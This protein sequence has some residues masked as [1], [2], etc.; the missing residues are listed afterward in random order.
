MRAV[1]ADAV[2]QITK[3]GRRS[4]RFDEHAACYRIRIQLLQRIDITIV[5][6]SKRCAGRHHAG[7]LLGIADRIL[8]DQSVLIPPVGITAEFSERI[9]LEYTLDLG[10]VKVIHIGKGR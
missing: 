2:L 6:S 10:G 7:A 3:I 4:L 8:H 1:C 9:S 5:Q